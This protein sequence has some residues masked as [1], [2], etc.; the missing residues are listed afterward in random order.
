MAPRTYFRVHDKSSATRFDEENGFVAGDPQLPLRMFPRDR[1]EYQ[2]LKLF[3]AIGRHLDW[4]NRTPS[5]FISVYADFDTAFNSASAR[6]NQGK[7]G[8]FVAVI[9]VKSSEN[10]WYRRVRE[11]ADDVG[12]WI[13]QQAWNNSEHE[14][15]FLHRIP[16]DAVVEIVSVS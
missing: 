12:L 16:S 14:Y 8:V 2:K 7:R 3:N 5:P 13:E 15:I 11:V 6:A 1:S 4:S 9:D 10:L